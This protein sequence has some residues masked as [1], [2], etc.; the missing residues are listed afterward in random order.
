[1]TASPPPIV[2]VFAGA[3]PTGGAG[4]EADILTLASLGCHPAPV[5]TAVTAQD[6]TGLKQFTVVE[7]E[8]I[9]AQARAVLEDMPVAAIKTGMLGNSA[10]V[11]AVESI[12]VDYPDIPVVVD[13]V[14][15][16]DGG[17]AL[18]EESLVAAL[19]TLLL[20]RTFLVTPNSQEAKL[21]APGADTLDACAQELMSLGCQYALVTGAQDNTPQVINRLYGN[22]R[23]LESFTCERLPENYHGSGCTL[24]SAC[25]AGLA[26][27][28]EPTHAVSQAL[29][30]TWQALK[31]GFRPGMGQHIP[32]RLHWLREG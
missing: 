10:V 18:V 3:D 20:P 8:L 21:L 22:M 28:L 13:P 1:V 23:L 17:Q 9:I 12:L 26:H 2:L 19:R 15:A 5:T 16:T 11:T 27:R 32:D 4:L 30:Y 31:H 29:R 24:A 6:T 25:A 7:T 14:Q